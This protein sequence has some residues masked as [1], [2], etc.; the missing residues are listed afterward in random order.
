MSPDWV[1]DMPCLEG[2]AIRFLLP[3]T[4]VLFPSGTPADALPGDHPRIAP[5]SIQEQ[6]AECLPDSETS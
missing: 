3:K 5:H 4:F 2:T 1:H 6:E